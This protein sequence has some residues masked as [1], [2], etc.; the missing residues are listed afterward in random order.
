MVYCSNCGNKLSNIV[1]FCE[2]CGEIVVR[3][4][5]SKIEENVVME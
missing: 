3:D 2:K 1:K 5:E 4:N